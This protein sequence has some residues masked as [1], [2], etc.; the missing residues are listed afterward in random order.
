MGPGSQA[1]RQR[2]A[3]PLCVSA[4]LAQASNFHREMLSL[5]RGAK[6]QDVQKRQ[7][8]VQKKNQVSNFTG[9]QSCRRK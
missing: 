3:K 7:S 8:Q 5:H 4:I 9:N 1:V 2:S 6:R